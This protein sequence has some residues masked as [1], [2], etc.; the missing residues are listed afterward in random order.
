MRSEIF[1]IRGLFRHGE[2]LGRILQAR[3]T[4]SC[5]GWKKTLAHAQSLGEASSQKTVQYSPAAPGEI[6]RS[7]LRASRFLP[8]TTCIHRALAGQRM[9]LRRQ[10][11]ARVVL[12]LR[13]NAGALEG[14]AWLEIKHLH[15]V[16]HLFWSEETGYRPLR[17]SPPEQLN[18]GGRSRWRGLFARSLASI[19]IQA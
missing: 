12:G 1:S 18:F 15:M 14:H 9:L 4:L 3:A 2:A 10:I 17:T 19:G 7:L 11:P 6:E 16:D 5:C 8:G 13:K